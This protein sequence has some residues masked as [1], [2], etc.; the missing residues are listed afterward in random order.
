MVQ[1]KIIQRCPADVRVIIRLSDLII[2]NR[3]A[4]YQ[5]HL[6]IISF[7]S[8]CVASEICF[9]NMGV[10]GDFLCAPLHSYLSDFQNI[11]PVRNAQSYLG[12]LLDQKHRQFFHIQ[13]GGIPSAYDRILC[14]Q[15]GAYGAKLVAEKRFG[16]G[17]AVVGGKMTYNS[18]VDIAGKTK[19]VPPDHELIRTARS[20][21][22]SFGD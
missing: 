18:L 6:S 4:V 14:T 20:I 16:V 13:R 17:A 10:A 21:G 22:V 15:I 12:I 9:N 5:A 2:R 7:A 1:V 3:I 8:F 19:L 11:C